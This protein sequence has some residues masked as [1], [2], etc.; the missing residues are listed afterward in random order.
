MK[1]YNPEYRRAYYLAHKERA[2]ATHKA[3]RKAN[4][5]K[6]HA[7]IKRHRIKHYDEC[8]EYDHKYHEKHRAHRRAKNLAWYRAHP[9]WNREKVQ[10]WRA[11]NRELYTLHDAARRKAYAAVKAGKL[12]RKTVCDVCG[13]PRKTEFHH[14]DYSKPLDVWQVCK[15]CHWKIENQ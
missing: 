5:E 9:E 11:T 4:P 1:K 10:A 6:Y 3:W 7:Q 8:V 15:P 2:M 12:V 14:P 13:L